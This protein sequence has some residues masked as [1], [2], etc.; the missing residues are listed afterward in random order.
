MRYATH[1]H[2]HTHTHIYIYI[3]VVRRQRVKQYLI[4]QPAESLVNIFVRSAY[5]NFH[6]VIM[7]EVYTKA[8]KYSKFYQKYVCLELK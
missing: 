7:R 5:F 4:Y 6:R 1:T 3:Y 2:T 8:Y